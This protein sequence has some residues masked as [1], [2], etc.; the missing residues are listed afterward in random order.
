LDV[1]TRLQFWRWASSTWA[2]ENAKRGAFSSMTTIP[3]RNCRPNGSIK[4]KQGQSRSSKVNQ[5]QARSIKVKQGQSRSIKVKQGQA[6]SIKV[7]QGQAR[8]IKVKQ[9]HQGQARSIKVKQGQQGQD[10]GVTPWAPSRR[11]LSRRLPPAGSFVEGGGLNWPCGGGV[12][13]LRASVRWRGAAP[14]IAFNPPPSPL[15]SAPRAQRRGCVGATFG[16]LL[17]LL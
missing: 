16:P 9:G 17:G 4:V 2:L 8:S 3:I 1:S 6:R 12:R 5:G 11:S 10:D 13:P 14:Q 7:N 15:T